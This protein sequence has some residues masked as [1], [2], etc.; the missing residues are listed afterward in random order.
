MLLLRAVNSHDA[1][2]FVDQLPFI[3]NP[4]EAIG[5]RS[6]TVTRRV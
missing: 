6:G 5:A 2:A 3:R 4:A 1:S